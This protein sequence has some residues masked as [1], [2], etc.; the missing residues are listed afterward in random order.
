MVSLKKSAKARV[1]FCVLSQIH[2][3]LCVQSRSYE[4]GQSTWNKGHIYSRLNR[5]GDNRQKVPEIVCYFF[6]IY[7]KK[8]WT[9]IKGSRTVIIVISSLTTKAYPTVYTS[10]SEQVSLSYTTPFTSQVRAPWRNQV[11][12]SKYVTTVTQLKNCWPQYI[13][14]MSTSWT[15]TL[16]FGICCTLS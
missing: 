9:D 1:R 12:Y 14:D 4:E 8:R 2:V 11:W 5:N 13:I 10:V 3:C 6:S 15:R 7:G 16:D